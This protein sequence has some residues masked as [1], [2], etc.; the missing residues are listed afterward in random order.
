VGGSEDLDT[1]T[2]NL[3][4]ADKIDFQRQAHKTPRMKGRG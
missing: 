1:T 3:I 2:I 4:E